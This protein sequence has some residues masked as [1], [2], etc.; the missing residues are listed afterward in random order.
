MEIGEYQDA[1]DFF[2]SNEASLKGSLKLNSDIFL[3]VV[4]R[5]NYVTL[6]KYVAVFQEVEKLSVMVKLV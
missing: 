3:L 4:M 1:N 2:S 5:L 6:Y